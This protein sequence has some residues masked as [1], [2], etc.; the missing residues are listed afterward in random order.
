[1]K[2]D[3]NERRQKEINAMLIET[4][5][6][7]FSLTDGILRHVESRVETALGPFARWILRVT[8][9]LDDVNADRGGI[10]K[11]CSIVVAM[12]RHGVEIAKAIDTDLYA[13]INE[14]AT[15]ARRS[16]IRT[17]KRHLTL[18]RRDAQ[19]PGALVT[20]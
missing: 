6:L 18:A 19:R 1:M 11:R 17:A 4:R 8:V 10:D 12:R 7:G 16:V 20:L 13:A 15:R 5:A 2:P 14:A 9:R 3:A